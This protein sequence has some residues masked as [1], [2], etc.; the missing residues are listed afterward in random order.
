MAPAKYALGIE[1]VGHF[2]FH[3]N[4]A[5]LL[6]YCPSNPQCLISAFLL[7]IICQFKAFT[8]PLVTPALGTSQG[9]RDIYLNPRTVEA[10]ALKFP[11]NLLS[12]MS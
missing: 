11:L 1:K 12:G 4:K 3:S 5:R 7:E 9:G 6:T 10:I 8:F 2:S